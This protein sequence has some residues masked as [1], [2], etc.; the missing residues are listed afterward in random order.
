MGRWLSIMQV[1]LGVD[2]FVNYIKKSDIYIDKSLF[3]RDVIDDKNAVLLITRP[4]RFGKTLNMTMLKA[5]FDITTGDENRQYFE[6]LKIWQCEEKYKAH[7]GKYPVIFMSFKDI[8]SDNWQDC[9]DG[10]KN[11]IANVFKEHKIVLNSLEQEDKEYYNNILF[12]R[13]TPSDF[14]QAIGN[15]T[16]W[17]EKYYNSKVI[18]LIDEYDAPINDGYNYGYDKEVILF[19]KNF[20]SYAMKTNDSLE[21]AVVTGLTKIAGKSLFSKLNH[22]IAYNVLKKEYSQYFGFT[23]EEVLLAMEKTSVKHNIEEIRSWYNGYNFGGTTPIY[24]PWSIMNV[25]A[26]PDEIL[27]SHWINTSSDGSLGAV[28]NNLSI[29]AKE[30]LYKLAKGDK[31]TLPLKDD[32]TYENLKNQNDLLWSFLLYAGYLTTKDVQE[33]EAEFFV[34]NYEVRKALLHTMERWILDQTGGTE[35]VEI[36]INAMLQ[37]DKSLFFKKLS[38]FVF[39]A[40]SYF[41]VTK[42]EPERVYHAFV[43]GLLC[44]VQNRFYVDSNPVA[45]YGRADVFIM[46][47]AGE[48]ATNAVILEFK[49]TEEDDKLESISKEALEQIKEKRY[50]SEAEKRGAKEVYAY[51]IG[52]CGRHIKVSMDKITFHL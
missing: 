36:L 27:R 47:K 39:N 10:F 7:L 8:E 34:P 5:Y 6:G 40:F 15:L 33:E 23:E 1:A 45:G 9:Y 48:L 26:F 51:G 17:L 29:S 2:I 11:K 25:C 37:G 44:H 20:F 43:L 41:D 35:E 31:I 52:F 3:V 21:K 50:I 46:P 32:V 42:T 18:L 16:H 24:N 49:Q 14:S 22:F 28:L 4:R 38:K 12:K 30:R 13:G 19:V